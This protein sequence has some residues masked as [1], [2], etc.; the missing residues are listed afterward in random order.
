MTRSIHNPG[1]KLKF[2]RPLLET[3]TKLLEEYFEKVQIIPDLALPSASKEISLTPLLFHAAR[4]AYAINNR[5]YLPA[6]E[7]PILRGNKTGRLDLALFSDRR[8]VLIEAKA[9]RPKLFGPGKAFNALES[10]L[11]AADR[12]LAATDVNTLKFHDDDNR[13]VTKIALATI[14]PVIPPSKIDKSPE[15]RFYEFVRDI[16]ANQRFSDCVTASVCYGLHTVNQP[17]GYKSIGQIIVA[18]EITL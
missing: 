5:E 14:N 8:I 4:Q 18:R 3:T 1:N 10:A 15:S 11:N 17:S 12:Q 6:A 13:K 16:R 9:R 2:L 7:V